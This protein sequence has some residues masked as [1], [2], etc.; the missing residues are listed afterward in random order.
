MQSTTGSITEPVNAGQGSKRKATASAAPAAAGSK[1][2]KS[3]AK[4]GQRHITAFFGGASSPASAAQLAAVKPEP[5]AAAEQQRATALASQGSSP[6]AAAQ[7]NAVMTQHAQALPDGPEDPS[8]SSAAVKAEPGTTT[9]ADV[10]ANTH[11]NATATA[12][13]SSSLQPDMQTHELISA[14]AAADGNRTAALQ[15]VPATD[16]D[17]LQQLAGQQGEAAHA[18]VPMQQGKRGISLPPA[19]MFSPSANRKKQRQPQRVV[20]PSPSPGEPADTST[21]SANAAEGKAVEEQGMGI[22]SGKAPGRHSALQCLKLV[23]MQQELCAIYP[24]HAQVPVI[25]AAMALQESKSLSDSA[26][27]Y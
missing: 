27:W 18:A 19:P 22:D 5:S 23:L 12:Q 17:A 25:I 24:L 11:R 26:L 6:Q 8:S 14:E 13:P 1:R 15:E 16:E 20:T 21:A 4:V 3:A 2:A 10:H 7:L 9:D